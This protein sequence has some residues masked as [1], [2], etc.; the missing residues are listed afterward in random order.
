MSAVEAASLAATTVYGGAVGSTASD[1]ARYA[2]SALAEAGTPTHLALGQMAR[3][4]RSRI[5]TPD[6]LRDVPG[7]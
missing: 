2:A 3:L 6:A 4:V 1:V 7:P 5:P